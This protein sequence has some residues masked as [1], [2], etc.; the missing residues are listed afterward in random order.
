MRVLLFG[1]SG[2][3]GKSIVNC[4]SF[5]EVSIDTVS[6]GK[7][8]N[9][10]IDI[11]SFD[12]FKKL[13]NNYYD[14]VINAATVLPGGDYLDNNY[15]N[16]IYE[17]N[18]LGSQ[19]ICKWI[20]TQS[21]IKKIINCSTLVVVNKPWQIPL[22]ENA[23]TY[24]LGNHVLYSSSKLMQELLFTT[25]GNLNNIPCVNLRFSSIYG[26]NMTKSGILF[27]LFS[28]IEAN[29]SI[30][31]T[32]GSKISFDFIHVDDAA[33]VIW[34]VV[35]SNCT[36]IL[37]VASGEEIKLIDLAKKTSLLYQDDIIIHNV[38]DVNFEEN[39]SNVEILKLKKI[40][41]TFNFIPLENGL[42][43]IITIWK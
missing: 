18:V 11:K 28:Q 38:N 6:R 14:V 12:D 16:N 42:K 3:L 30:E 39:F 23:K 41:K 22:D 29:K 34:Q 43:E 20:K 19:N 7:K 8:C 1:G 26:K 31:I 5:D 10:Q 9:Y 21:T 17:T 37:N 32:N 25:F 13:P 24:P 36:G 15:L 2:F 40:M 27:N 4:F 35:N 33:R